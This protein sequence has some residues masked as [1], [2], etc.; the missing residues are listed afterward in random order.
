MKGFGN[1]SYADKIRVR[2]W[3][4][5]MLLIA[6]LVFM[7]VVGELGLG[8]SRI[9]SELAE[10]VSRILFFGG[11]IWVILKISNQK[12]L[13]QHPGKLKAQ[14]REEQDERNRYI[15]DKSGGIVWDVLFVVLLFVTL[16][17]SLSN[18]AAFYTSFSIL[19]VAVALKLGMVFYLSR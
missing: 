12:Q 5:R 6:M 4:L 1:L 10:T 15:H 9:M 3:L 8:D 17:A 19:L 2:I 16:T 13:L 18:M 14:M 7:V 11:M